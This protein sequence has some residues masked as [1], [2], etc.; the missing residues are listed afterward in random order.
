MSADRLALILARQKEAHDQ[1]TAESEEERRRALEKERRVEKLLETWTA[2]QGSL[3]AV[4]AELNAAMTANGV[5]LSHREETFLAGV[6]HSAEIGYAQPPEYVST[7]LSLRLYLNAQGLLTVAI[8]GMGR[9]IKNE[10][11]KLGDFVERV[12]REWLLD[13]LEITVEAEADRK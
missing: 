12:Q 8:V 4:V 5:V 1:R 10:K 3:R 13:F 9:P 2:T 6:R 7:G 11:M